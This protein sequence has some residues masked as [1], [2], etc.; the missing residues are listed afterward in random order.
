MDVGEKK[1]LRAKVADEVAEGLGI[2]EAAAAQRIDHLTSQ[3]EYTHGV[4]FDQASEAV[5][6]S[7]VPDLITTLAEGAER[8]RAL[9]LVSIHRTAIREMRNP[10]QTVDQAPP[11][12]DA[13]SAGTTA[14]ATD[15]SSDA[16]AP[17]LGAST[18]GTTVADPALG[19]S[20][21]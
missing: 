17:A 19:A 16:A 14:A 5:L 6:N 20:A 21:S 11:S 2:T 4:N 7:E 8:P 9:K 15:S 1:A 12:T 13:S 10:R 18:P 3:Y